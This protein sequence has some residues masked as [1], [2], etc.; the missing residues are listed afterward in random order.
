MKAIKTRHIVALVLALILVASSV[1]AGTFAF[2]ADLIYREDIGKGY[3]AEFALSLDNVFDPPNDWRAGEE[4]S[5][6]VYV[7]N[8]GELDGYVRLSY[9]ETLTAVEAADYTYTDE[10]YAVNPL[11]GEYYYIPAGTAVGDR[12]AAF[13]AK[14][15][16]VPN[17]DFSV[18]ASSIVT[19][20]D[21]I[22][23]IEA[24]YI[25]VTDT[26][27][28]ALYP[29]DVNGVYGR[30]MVTEG[31][32]DKPGGKR[33]D[34][35]ANVADYV[36][37]TW[38][39]SVITYADW[40]KTKPAP[41]DYWVVD[42]ATGYIYYGQPLAPKGVTVNAL[43]SATLLKKPEGNFKYTLDFTLESV[44]KTDL[45][46][47]YDDGAAAALYSIDRP[48]VEIPA[49]LASDMWQG[50]LDGTSPGEPVLI[51]LEKADPED[52]NV[53]DLRY[54]LVVTKDN[55]VITVVGTEPV[56]INTTSDGKSWA[57]KFM[58]FRADAQDTDFIIDMRDSNVLARL[59][60]GSA[61]N[62]FD[63]MAHNQD[64][65]TN[66][67]PAISNINID[68][69]G[70]AYSNVYRNA[71]G[72][73]IGVV[74]H[75]EDSTITVTDAIFYVGYV[76]GTNY[77][78]VIGLADYINT[79]ELVKN[80]TIE[81]VNCKFYKVAKTWDGD[82][83]SVTEADEVAWDSTMMNTGTTGTGNKII[84]NGITVWSN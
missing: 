67:A 66:P 76:S 65:A 75:V 26:A 2:K 31:S 59:N 47:W 69:Y 84:V 38:N 61:G 24:L 71:P 3:S 34:Y 22:A 80:C 23:D 19:A 37:L 6:P 35:T 33:W 7:H 56:I 46:E 63:I 13:A 25:K 48:V 64:A 30:S 27:G 17:V 58:S 36:E 20:Y 29:D 42:E 5:D 82:V 4:V 14:Y 28:N 39:S 9:T 79:E 68:I 62:I 40:L 49:E 77:G 70:G 15:S 51:T 83:S 41:G 52:S 16:G 74:G 60:H 81:L 55:P 32:I 11:T 50:I 1:I 18:Y 44:S 53:V 78:D 8:V 43:E 45:G 54:P 73:C 21:Y 10:E 72:A 12:V 57:S